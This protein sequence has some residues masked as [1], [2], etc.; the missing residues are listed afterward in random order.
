M[1]IAQVH[2]TWSDRDCGV[3]WL[4]RLPEYTGKM[5]ATAQFVDVIASDQS[6]SL[7]YSVL[8]DDQYLFIYFV[9][10]IR[11]TRRA[12]QTPTRFVIRALLCRLALALSIMTG[13]GP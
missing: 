9:M 3:A 11:P 12:G 4:A 10:R 8:P 2:V 7:A 13:H 6:S 1:D 5:G